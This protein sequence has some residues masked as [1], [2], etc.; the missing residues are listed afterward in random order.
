MAQRTGRGPAAGLVGREPIL[1][2]DSQGL[3]RLFS[4][5]EIGSSRFGIHLPARDRVVGEHGHHVVEDLCEAAADR[6]FLRRTVR[7]VHEHPRLEGGEECG[8]VRQDTELAEGTWPRDFLNLLVEQLSLGGDD[9]E[10]E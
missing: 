7:S 2:V 8:V 1:L 4:G 6:D 9:A 5:L 10:L 3:Q